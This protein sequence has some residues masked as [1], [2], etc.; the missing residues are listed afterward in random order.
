MLVAVMDEMEQQLKELLTYLNEHM[1][2][3]GI[4]LKRY[5]VKDYAEVLYVTSY[6]KF[7]REHLNNEEFQ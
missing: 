7:I 2:I 5:D 3:H 4:E 1:D 6:P